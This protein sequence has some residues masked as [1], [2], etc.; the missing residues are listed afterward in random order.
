MDLFA[1]GFNVLLYIARWF[2]YG[3]VMSNVNIDKNTTY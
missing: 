1:E 3:I 2:S